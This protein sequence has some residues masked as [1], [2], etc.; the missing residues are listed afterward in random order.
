MTVRLAVAAGLAAAALALAA[1]APAADP[2]PVL[3][4]E[5]YYD[6]PGADAGYEFVELFN[7]GDAAVS[8][9]GYRLQ[10]GD[11][12]GPARWRT[13]WQG[14]AGDVI[15]ARARF[16]LGEAQLTA[17][18]DRALDL[19]LENGPDALRLTAPD[20]RADL[21]GYGALTYAEYFAGEPAPDVAAGFSLARA[22]DG[23]DSGD[24]RRDFLALSP[25]TPG[26]ANRP[27]RDA[28]L[29]AAAPLAEPELVEPG[30]TVAVRARFV[31]RGVDPL[32]GREVRVLL[33]SAPAADL[34]PAAEA[35]A[36]DPDG[37]LAA[38]SLVAQVQ[39]ADPL[40]PGDSLA[41]ALAWTAPASGAYRLAV[42]ARLDDDGVEG[43]DRLEAFVR[44]GPG[45]LRVS[46]V[47]YAPLP[48][49]PE[50]V[51]VRAAGGAPVDLRRFRLADAT[52]R[53]GVPQTA[54]VAALL[55]PDSLALLTEDA[56]ALCALRPELD[57]FRVLTVSPWPALNNSAA[58][59]GGAA[60]RVVLRDDRGLVADAMAYAPGAP[61]GYSVERRDPERPAREA[62]NWGLSATA[63]GTPLAPNS[64]LAA[65]AGEA[66]LRLS[67][68]VWRRG[69][70]PPRVSVAYRLA[71][72]RAV[73]RLTVIDA[74][75]RER[76]RLHDGPSAAAAVL[77]WDGKGADGSDL[78]PGAYALALEARPAAGGGRVRLTRP[79]VV[80]P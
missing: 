13:V 36:A 43:N 17:P 28:E 65:P 77:E 44:A 49:E 1:P 14:Q 70:G 61:A 75:G 78:G 71:W 37:A 19:G 66:G 40:E 59:A 53:A 72:E 64:A 76:A 21:V 22:V 9:A 63:G 3:L 42:T 18:P 12:A 41:V 56:A 11:G 2:P 26:A 80:E 60:D 58:E 39:G 50:W 16:T 68:R 31:N 79:L 23:A 10:A 51:E 38:D 48:G 54:G 6:H 32:A 35:E 73:V 29:T 33:W 46:E 20:G 34:P 4:N 45:P 5:I 7:T 8:L 62:D 69:G 55:E 52:G 24:N 57:R 74:R 30:E 27:E 15:A 67:P 25:P 47:L